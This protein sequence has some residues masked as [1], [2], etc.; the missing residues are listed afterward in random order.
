MIFGG[1]IRTTIRHALAT[2][3][4]LGYTMRI[5]QGTLAAF[6]TLIIVPFFTKLGGVVEAAVIVASFLI[7]V[8]A[9]SVRHKALLPDDHKIVI[10]EMVSI[11][12]TF[13]LIETDHWVPVLLTGFFFNRLFDIAKPFPLAY[14]ERLPGGWGIMADD[15]LAGIGANVILHILFALMIF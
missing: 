15:L 9:S 4:G 12:V 14:A 8:W 11:L 1:A 7:G 10:D 13:F 6:L 5:G 2:G 3:F